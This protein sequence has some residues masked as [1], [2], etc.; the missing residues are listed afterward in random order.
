MRPK[1]HLARIL[2]ILPLLFHFSCSELNEELNDMLLPTEFIADNTW[3]EDEFLSEGTKWYKVKVDEQLTTLYIEW[4]ELNYHGEKKSYTANIIVSAYKLDGTSMYFENM[5]LG[6]G[7]NSISFA[8]ENEAA[9]LLKVELKDARNKGSFALRANGSKVVEINY[10]DLSLGDTWKS[11]TINEDETIGYKVSC[12]STAKVAI[13]WAEKDSPEEGYTAEIAGSVLQEDG[14]TIYK[15]L[16]N[17][18]DILNKNKSHSNEPRTI[19]LAEGESDFKIH[20]RVNTS[21]GTYAIKV[22]QITN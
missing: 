22:I 17:G 19:Q 18:K 13:I 3:F 12:G 11:G 2:S 7:S 4:A 6:Y 21:P 10:L 14:T 1:I 16:N 20:L 9:V 5:D 8:T 15:D